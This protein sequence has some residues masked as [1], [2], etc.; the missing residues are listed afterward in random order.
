MR[1][2]DGVV[3]VPAG[4]RT[5]TVT[6][7]DW[8][9][10][11]LLCR[12]GDRP[13]KIKPFRCQSTLLGLAMEDVSERR[14]VRIAQRALHQSLVTELEHAELVLCTPAVHVERTEHEAVDVAPGSRGRFAGG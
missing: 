6:R 12:C 3:D 10:A 1:R 8:V 14:R 13:G 7:T 11:H 4:N 5:A 2:D 9:S